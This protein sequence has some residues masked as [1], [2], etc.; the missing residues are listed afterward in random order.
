V[1]AALTANEVNWCPT[2]AETSTSSLRGDSPWTLS[3]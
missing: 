3:N 1:I 2:S